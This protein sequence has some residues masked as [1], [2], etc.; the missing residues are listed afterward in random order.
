MKNRNGK[1][2]L[3]VLSVWKTFSFLGK[4]PVWLRK[5]QV[6][7]W[8]VCLS[9]A[10]AFLW[11]DWKHIKRDLVLVTPN[12]MVWAEIGN[13][14]SICFCIVQWCQPAPQ[15]NLFSTDLKSPVRPQAILSE[16]KPFMDHHLV[17]RSLLP[18]LCAAV[19]DKVIN[20]SWRHDL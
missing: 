12:S 17:I 13:G 4:H 2:V 3:K 6:K 1:V 19:K 16:T 5:E 7:G 14:N 9:W 10:A 8:N 20:L 11:S 18:S 15:N